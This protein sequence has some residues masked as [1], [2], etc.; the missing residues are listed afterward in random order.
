MR[1]H[2]KERQAQTSSPN[3]PPKAIV[4]GAREGNIGGAIAVHLCH[5]GWTAVEDDCAR[6]EFS[7]NGYTAPPMQY[8]APYDACVITL[9]VTHMEPFSKVEQAD[10]KKVLYGCLELPLECARR[11]VRARCHSF[12]K[13]QQGNPLLGKLVFI[14]S[15]A[16][17]HPFTHCTSYCAA[18]AG[19][20][21]AA[22]SLAWEL[23]P[24]GFDV[25]IVHPH[26]VQGTPMTDVVRQG[27]K[28]GV[29]HMTDEEA[30]AYTRK[31]LR[32][33]DILKPEEVAQM[34]GHLLGSKTLRWT[35]G[36]SIKMYGGVR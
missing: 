28:E 30:E 24:E 16:H 33:P 10:L 21:M 7:Y 18:K 17:D 22:R 23:M 32:M 1:H 8:L 34:V 13:W 4:L 3:Q 19:L 36:T 6:G 26:H 9:G 15:Y 2:Y 27:M 25:F 14:G 35:S 12:P 31:D 20:D 29:H 5:N 11:Y